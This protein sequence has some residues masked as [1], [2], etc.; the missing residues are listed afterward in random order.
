MKKETL[1]IY[2]RCSTDNQIQNSINRQIDM[3]IKFSKKMNMKHKVWS[4]EG[5]SGLKSF[6]NTREQFTEL[7]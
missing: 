6:E 4:D 3:G 2:V 7:M 1:H 5:K